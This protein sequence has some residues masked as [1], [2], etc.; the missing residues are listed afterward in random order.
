VVEANL[1]F[2]NFGSMAANAMNLQDRKNISFK[3]NLIRQQGTTCQAAANNNSKDEMPG[4]HGMESDL[5]GRVKPTQ[6]SLM[7]GWSLIIIGFPTISH[8]ESSG[9]SSIGS[10]SLANA[11][12]RKTGSF[13]FKNR[14]QQ[15]SAGRNA[16]LTAFCHRFLLQPRAT[17]LRLDVFSTSINGLRGAAVVKQVSANW[18]F[19]K[20]WQPQDAALTSTS[21]VCLLLHNLDRHDGV[22]PVEAKVV[23]P[24]VELNKAH[25]MRRFR[26]CRDTF[27]SDTI[28]SHHK[29]SE[30]GQMGRRSNRAGG[31]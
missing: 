6:A 2:L 5:K 31:V 18:V 26:Q 19:L 22:S 8:T 25:Q 24:Q 9:N 4:M 23:T 30:P 20:V 10:S 13:V 17:M 28:F 21:P 1:R 16:F 3:L 12:K 7:F 29:S 14:D 27:G 11:R 15:M